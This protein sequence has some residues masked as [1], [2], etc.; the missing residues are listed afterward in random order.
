MTRHTHFRLHDARNNTLERLR[1]GARFDLNLSVTV[2]GLPSPV[3]HRNL[4]R[5]VQIVVR[6]VRREILHR[7][8]TGCQRIGS[9]N[10]VDVSVTSLS[11][12]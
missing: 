1:F 4:D 3:L 5:D 6:L 12:R 7:K 11:L 9:I 8:Q 2:V 10:Y